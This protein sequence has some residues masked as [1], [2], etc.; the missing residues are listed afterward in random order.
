MVVCWGYNDAGE[1][2]PPPSLGAVSAITAGADHTCAIRQLG[3]GVV[4]WGDNNEIVGG[5]YA[6]QA[7]PPTD[8]GAVSALSAGYEHT[9]AI[10]QADASVVCWG[11]IN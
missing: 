9:C 8:L 1:V 3:G 10:L 2:S 5:G 4:C 7:T 6:G 11:R